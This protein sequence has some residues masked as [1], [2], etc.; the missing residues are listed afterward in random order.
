MSD[1]TSN[2]VCCV[3]SVTDTVTY[4]DISVAT[5]SVNTTTSASQCEVQS[6][7][8]LDNRDMISSSIIEMCTVSTATDTVRHSDVAL[9]TE[10][11]HT[12]DNAAQSES[13]DS[14]YIS[15]AEHC[16]IVQKYENELQATRDNLYDALTG[17]QEALTSSS[18]EQYS[19]TN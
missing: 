15:K 5:D 18:N 2:P 7:I 8:S 14:Y 11:L 1:S 10:S 9:A 13:F 4:S 19:G 3:C 6:D 12:S 16:D 17:L